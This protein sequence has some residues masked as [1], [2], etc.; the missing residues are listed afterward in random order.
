MD[1]FLYDRELRHK[2]ENC[3]RFLGHCLRVFI[4]NNLISLS[5]L[6]DLQFFSF[7]HIIHLI[8]F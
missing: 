7:V 4:N 8:T 2:S 5:Y 6:S 1:W 3:F